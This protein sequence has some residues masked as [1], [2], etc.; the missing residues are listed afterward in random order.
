MGE[1]TELQEKI[2]EYTEDIKINKHFLKM[3][4][5]SPSENTI[6]KN[7]Q[8]MVLPPS[9]FFGDLA[10]LGPVN[11]SWSFAQVNEFSGGIK[12]GGYATTDSGLDTFAM[13]FK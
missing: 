11:P 2:Q 3:S 5:K 10:N 9:S 1:S 4:P 12:D 7:S 8:F 6:Q 13:T